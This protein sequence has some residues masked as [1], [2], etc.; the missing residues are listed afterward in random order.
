MNLR[1]GLWFAGTI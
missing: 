1:P